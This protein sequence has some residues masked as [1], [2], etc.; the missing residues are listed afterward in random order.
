M[1]AAWTFPIWMRE[2]PTRAWRMQM[3]GTEIRTLEYRGLP[4]VAR[5]LVSAEW[6]NMK[7]LA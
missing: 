4:D 3:P 6:A 7:T 1:V 5:C 2:R